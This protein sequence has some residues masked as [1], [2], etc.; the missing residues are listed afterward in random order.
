MGSTF[1]DDT[2]AVNL[3]E[4]TVGTSYLPPGWVSSNTTGNFKWR[5]IGLSGGTFDPLTGKCGAINHIVKMYCVPMTDILSTSGNTAMSYF[6][7][8]YFYYF[9]AE[10]VVDGTC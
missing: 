9:T 7:G 4:R 10:N 6:L 5:P 2:W 8:R 3:N 1:Q